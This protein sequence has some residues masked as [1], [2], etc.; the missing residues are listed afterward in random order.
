MLVAVI[1]LLGTT[2]EDDWSD[3]KTNPFVLLNYA[4]LIHLISLWIDTHSARNFI[5]NK[6]TTNQVCQALT[7][8]AG[9]TSFLALLSHQAFLFNTYHF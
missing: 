9:H 2:V 8:G 4:Y 5:Y 1:S 3:L 7:H 6:Y